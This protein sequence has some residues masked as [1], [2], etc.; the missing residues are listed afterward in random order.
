[1]GNPNTESA[2]E[3]VRINTEMM[4]QYQGVGLPIFRQGLDAVKGRLAEGLPEYVNAAYRGANTSAAE[5]VGASMDANLGAA[6]RGTVGP[7]RLGAIANLYAGGARALAQEKTGIALAKANTKISDR[8]QLIGML[9]GGGFQATD[10]AAGFGGLTNQALSAA[11]RGGNPIY[12][13]I[14]GG[15]AAGSQLFLSALAKKPT[16]TITPTQDQL[17]SYG[18]N[19]AYSGNLFAPV[20]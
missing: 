16:S 14:V 9:A 18:T 12:E 15:T 5:A 20:L 19:R 8:E 6:T 13:S 7:A 3:A 4:R 1:M 10:L 2:Q 11:A 17:T